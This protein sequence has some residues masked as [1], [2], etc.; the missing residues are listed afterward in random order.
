MASLETTFLIDLLRNRAAAIELAGT[1][2]ASGE[3][4]CVT[5]PA[6]AEVLI[7]A[8]LQGG[9]SLERAKELLGS[10]V[11]LDSDRESYTE[12]GRLGALLIARGEEMSTPDLFI[13][14]SSKRHGQRLDPRDR[15]FGRIAALPAEPYQAGVQAKG[16]L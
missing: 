5:A 14:A 11:L 12:A 4:R 7:G 16:R 1:L 9:R 2:D 13:A 15:T 6:A 10:L 3:P 8:H